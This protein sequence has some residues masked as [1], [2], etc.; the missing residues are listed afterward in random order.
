MSALAT[1]GVPYCWPEGCATGGPVTYQP[2]PS[3]SGLIYTQVSAGQDHSCGVTTDNAAYCWGHNSVGQFGAGTIDSVGGVPET[4][5]SGDLH[6][7]QISAGGLR[8]CGVTTD[9]VAYCW[10][11]SFGTL[12]DGTNDNVLRLT[13]TRVAGDL[14][15]AQVSAGWGHMCGVT[16][17]NVAYCW[18]KNRY[19]YP[20]KGG[21]LG[22][23]TTEDRLTPT[24]VAGDLRFT[25]VS[26]GSD[27]T[28]GV[29]TDTLFTAGDSTT[30][31]SSEVSSALTQGGAGSPRLQSNRRT[32]KGDGPR[33]PGASANP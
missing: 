13:P 10:G 25:Q 7:A 2:A 3:P 20:V 33:S 17:D 15:F 19:E 28:C 21:M 12:G 32:K 5:V 14:R 27:H 4:P 22:D 9:N 6:F 23:G 8:T 29:T 26:V 1:S 24:R 31:A 18:G 11:A 16:T 30:P